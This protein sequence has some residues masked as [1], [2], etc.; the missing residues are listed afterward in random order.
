MSLHIFPTITATTLALAEQLITLA[1]EAIK[2]TNRFSLVLSGGNTPKKLYELLASPAFRNKI[3]WSKVQFYFGDERYVPAN[4]K[5]SNYKMAME[6]LLY[7]LQISNKQ[8]FPIDTSLPVQEAAKA[9]QKS[10]SENSSIEALQFDVVLLG[11]G[12]NVHTASLFPDTDV[13]S[14]NQPAIRAVLLPDTKQYRIT[15]N[16]PLINQAKHI[17]FYVLG[18]DKAMAVHQAL[19]GKIDPSL[20][21][22]QLIHTDKSAWYLDEAAAA[23]L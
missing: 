6:S 20:F 5:D 23:Y 8:I 13:L 18:I 2:T 19:Q 22:A 21:P 17:C 10:I 11:L 9:Y 12:D 15:M 16:A 14:D 7:P 1:E 4:D 3:D